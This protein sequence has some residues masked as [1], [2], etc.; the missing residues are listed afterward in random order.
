MNLQELID[1]T[2][3]Y[4]TIAL[5]FNEYFGQVLIDKP[6]TIEGNHSTVCAKHGPVIHITSE[7]VEIRNLRIEVTCPSEAAD[8][9]GFLALS[10]QEFLKVRLHNVV[11]KGN[12]SGIVLEDG[13]W[14][15][16]ESLHI[17][18]VVPGRKNSFV[19]EMRVPVSC[20]LETDIS[21]LR[22]L[23]PGLREPGLHRIKL[24][25]N[26]LKK[27]TVLFG[28]IEIKSN[29]LR[30]IIAVS[31]GSFL[32]EEEHAES[33]EEHPI[34]LGAK[35]QPSEDKKIV[36]KPVPPVPPV[37]P[38][39][40]ILLIAAFLAV[41]AGLTY[42]LIPKKPAEDTVKPA[43]EI[44]LSKKLWTVGDTV[45]YRVK[46][47]DNQQ[48]ETMVFRVHGTEIETTWNPMKPSALFDDSFS[49]GGWK[50]G[51]YTCILLVTD[52]A[53]NKSEEYRDSFVLE[54]G[55]E[56]FLP[57]KDRE[58][59]HA[60]PDVDRIK[61]SGEITGLKKQYTQGDVIRCTIIVNDD[62]ELKKA[63]FEVTGSSVKKSWNIRG[64]SA[65]LE[66]SF[67]TQNWKPGA[68]SCILRMEDEAGNQNEISG[69]FELKSMPDSAKPSGKISGIRA[70]YMQGDTVE[71][72]ITV[73]DD[74]ALKHIVFEVKNTDIHF[75]SD[76]ADSAFIRSSFFSTKNW[77][78]GTYTCVLTI[79]DAAGNQAEIRQDFEVQ[80]LPRD[81]AK[82]SGK[83]S[84]IRDKYTQGD[85][86]E[87]EI[88]AKDDNAL[89]R[90]A[91]EVK[92]TDIRFS[93]D[94]SDAD[95]R[96]SSSFPTKNLKPGTYTCVLTAEDAAGNHAE[97]TKDFEVQAQIPPPPQDT[98]KPSGKISMKQDKYTQGD[99]VEYE[100]SAKDDNALKRIA[101]EVK[102]TEIRFSAD[103]SDRNFRRGSSFSTKNLKP[104]T[105]TCVL[106]AEDA[107]GNHAEI[108]KDFEVQAHVP[109]PSFEG[110]VKELTDTGTWN[111]ADFLQLWISKSDVKIG[112]IISF[113]FRSEKDCYVNIA[114]LTADGELLQ[115]FPNS[116]M[117]KS[118]V[119]AKQAYEIPGKDAPIELEVTGPAG[120]EKVI[121][122]VSE[123]P[124]SIFEASFEKGY[125]FTVEKK[126]ER[127]IRKIFENIQKAK[128]Q[129]I[130]QKQITYSIRK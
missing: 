6:L 42:W 82:P 61:P 100:I 53:G 120:T 57:E 114:Y 4:G 68:Y 107:A 97:I 126:N 73:K 116:I 5:E 35:F 94:T 66:S 45:T 19:F 103:S 7:D 96:R 102:N 24:E 12:V 8:E 11:V 47:E 55:G 72:S 26:N 32:A 44:H 123:K 125:F 117:R 27:D 127:M 130:W 10:V 25:V 3:E 67:S 62:T 36:Q 65:S 22:I 84:G 60:V 89:K 20:S 39:K 115:L 49:T 63:V 93:A 30:R 14:E 88:T 129:K 2:E 80:D 71:Y 99:T 118:S 38:V 75:S 28:K 78:P 87:Y 69:S 54:K 13:V 77:K 52:R 40:K 121:A 79:E 21:G 122:L 70:I 59:P 15:Y 110:L 43:G 119:K 56:P 98:A 95:F 16:P 76:P 85:T 33:D 124:F 64:Q 104:G 83:I 81:T 91:F 29:Y 105:Y 18:P 92:N 23:T 111:R 113:H 74:R 41:I 9:K 108:T 51:S 86:V 112:D 31:G 128:E 90:I 1:K 17:W 46:A 101:F 37:P 50:P 109:P 48:A 106:T 58:K 34:F